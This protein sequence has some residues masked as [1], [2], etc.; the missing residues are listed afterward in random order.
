VGFLVQCH[1][2]SSTQS[3]ETQGSCLWI[4]SCGLYYS[5]VMPWYRRLSVHNPDQVNDPA[6]IL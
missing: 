2:V 3:K 6:V 5:G 4:F 1:I